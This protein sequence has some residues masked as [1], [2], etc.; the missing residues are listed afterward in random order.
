[1]ILQIKNYIKSYIYKITKKINIDYDFY[2]SYFYL[3]DMEN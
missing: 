2:E 1:M 3:K